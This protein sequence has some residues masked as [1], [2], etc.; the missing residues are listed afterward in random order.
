MSNDSKRLN[1]E[2]I[3]KAIQKEENTKK[4]G[5]LRVFLG[6]CPG[7]GKTYSMLKAGKELAERGKNVV[8]G[9]VETHGR[10]D[11]ADMLK[12]IP[13][14]ELKKVRYREKEFEEMD[15]EK[16]LTL[17]PKPHLVIVDELAHQNTPGSRHLK[18]YQDIEELLA[19][20]L[21]VYTTVNIQHIESRNDQVAQITGIIVKETV[22]DSF[23][24][25]AN[26][27]EIVD[28]NPSE[29]LKRL[30][31]GKVYLGNV[32]QRAKE[33]FF[34]EERLTALRELSLRFTAEKVDRTLSQ[35]MMLKGIEGPWNI[36]EKL[37][38]AVSSYPDSSRL[39]R[40]ARRIAY[41]LDAPWIVL[42]VDTGQQ[43]SEKDQKNIEL[44]LK[45]AKEL[46]AEVL[47]VVDVNVEK[48]IGQVC[49]EQNVTQI[50]MGRPEKNFLKN[51]FTSGSLL[52]RLVLA[53]NS[54]DIHVL[55]SEKNKNPAKISIMPA[56][57]TGVGAYFLALM[58]N[59]GAALIFYAF[60]PY[61][62]YNSLGS[63]F[64]II[65]MLIAI[66]ARQGPAIFS[67]VFLALIWYFLFI[68]TSQQYLNNNAQ[69]LQLQNT[70][71]VV[72]FFITAIVAILV[73]SRISQQEKLM[74]K[75]ESRST[76]LYKFTNEINN[77]KKIDEI[78][79]I[80][81]YTTAKILESDIFTVVADKNGSI[82]NS[83]SQLNLPDKDLAVAN[84]TFQSNTKSGKFT[85]TLSGA[86]YICYPI[87]TENLMV[88]V[89][90]IKPGENLK[91]LESSDDSLITTLNKQAAKYIQN[92]NLEIANQENK[93][94][95][96]QSTLYRRIFGTL[97]N[98]FSPTVRRIN[99]IV[100]TITDKN[101]NLENTKSKILV[102]IS[103]LNSTL[104]NIGRIYSLENN[105]NILQITKFRL[106]DLLND[107]IAAVK[108]D[109]I[110]IT[111][112]KVPPVNIAADYNLLKNAF[113]NILNNSVQ[114][115]SKNITI[116]AKI[117]LDKAIIKFSDDGPGIPAGHE[118]NIFE[119]FY[120]PTNKET[121]GLGLAVVKKVI[122]KHSG[123]I[124]VNNLAQGASFS[125]SLPIN[126]LYSD[127]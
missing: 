77:T 109:E 97:S 90:I 20:G 32:A 92:I 127:V 43:L 1:P 55:R 106:D 98:N 83:L 103:K 49:K 78:L 9:I 31:E 44:H 122:D 33:N 101:I 86:D 119:S 110:K 51:F 76:L 80:L 52:D 13:Q 84:W 123:E 40:A 68:P 65:I 23:F 17:N 62:G 36:N 8:I 39:I 35:Q 61:A 117:L 66:F 94:M 2:T 96:V 79:K 10:K 42:H 91:N 74:T 60:L 114:V 99:E 115:K 7:V 19:N 88:G 45:L 100:K 73:T 116:D 56:F 89:L 71:M 59:L 4:R 107:T 105:K 14:I 82:K 30:N 112:N 5:Q 124:T 48:A 47:E 85:K 93:L 69:D 34:R 37:L 24:D 16:I 26:N 15:L 18:R 72:W 21:N 54:V 126:H 95:L 46:G 81:S 6:M 38:V 22:P 75:S 120:T 125:I 28:L 58:I 111:V 3:L 118:N 64:L 63:G 121:D 11:T 25:N 70:I 108:N 12:D 67:A 57:S 104:I 87:S 53:D 113:I 27:I 29:L 102:M 41:N 50:I